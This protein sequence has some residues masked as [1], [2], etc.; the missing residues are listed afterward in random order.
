MVSFKGLFGGRNGVDPQHIPHRQNSSGSLMVSSQPGMCEVSC[1]HDRFSSAASH[2]IRSSPVIV[3][4]PP[5]KPGL[6][7]TAETRRK[8]RFR[9]PLLRK[10]L[11]TRPPD[12]QVPA[13]QPPQQ[14]C[15]RR[16]L[17]ASTLKVIFSP[18][19]TPPIIY[20]LHRDAARQGYAPTCVDCRKQ[21]QAVGDLCLGC[22]NSVGRSNEPRLR[23]LNLQDPKA[24]SGAF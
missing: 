7:A 11:C 8:Y 15:V 9:P 12:L 22:N 6:W 19:R 21:P 24:D 14:I 17:W 23:E 2:I 1:P 3:I 4:S 13:L 5:Q 10:N 20:R 18:T 16:I